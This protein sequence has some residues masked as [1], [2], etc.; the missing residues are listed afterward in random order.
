MKIQFR[1][2]RT[3]DGLDHLIALSHLFFDE[4]QEH[5]PDFFK[6]DTLT[7]D[8]IIQYFTRLRDSERSTVF[9]A[10]DGERIV[11]YI[12]LNIKKQADYWAVKEVGNISGLMVHPAYRRLGIARELLAKAKDFFRESKVRYFTVYTSAKN[13]EGIKFYKS[14]GLSV[15]HKTFI[16]EI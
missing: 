7:D 16:G 11:G 14:A 8:D 9:I 2:L 13:E 5:H 10:L 4:Y 6:I 15:L 3:E 12:T 1:T